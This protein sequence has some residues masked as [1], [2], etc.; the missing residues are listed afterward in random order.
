MKNK[1]NDDAY[2][3]LS[4]K[5]FIRWDSCKKEVLKILKTPI[6]NADLSW[7][8]CDKRFIDKVKLL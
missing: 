8:N 3:D 4:D 7:E 6:Q 5:K 1:N 2:T